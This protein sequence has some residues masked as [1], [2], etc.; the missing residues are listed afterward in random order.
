MGWGEGIGMTRNE[1]IKKLPR[2]EFFKGGHT[3]CPGCPG[4]ILWRL[5]TKVMGE[6]SINTL[7]ATCISLPPA[8]FPSVLDIPSIYVSMATPAPLISGVSAA[9]RILKRKGKLPKDEKI[10]VF[11]VAGDG[12]TADIGFAGLSGAAERNDDGIYFCF[13]NE[14]YMNTGI[15]RSS[16]TPQKTWTT[17]TLEGKLQPKKD[18]PKIMAAHRIPYV[19]TASIGFPDDLIMKAENARDMERGFRYI[20]VHSPCPAGWRF[21]EKESIEIAR[22]AVDS[23]MWLLFE[24]EHEELRLTH[25]PSPRKSVQEYLSRQGRFTHLTAKDVEAIQADVDRECKKFN[26]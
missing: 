23:G 14:A 19:A 15:Q 21:P 13:D 22:L 8:V 17:S 25:K 12:G 24:I 4:G 10:N 11:A 9:L 16:Q 5:V 7:G 26:L 20:H 2:R 6:N 18:L 1:I 3:L